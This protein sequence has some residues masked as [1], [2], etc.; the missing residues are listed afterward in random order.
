MCE[1]RSA[2]P[3]RYTMITMYVYIYMLHW[4]AYYLETLFPQRSLAAHLF[5]EGGPSFRRSKAWTLPEGQEVK[6]I[7]EKTQDGRTYYWSRKSTL[8][9]LRSY[10]FLQTGIW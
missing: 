1:L 8:E 6:W 3:C 2:R 4:H 7:G 5:F 10:P 9:K